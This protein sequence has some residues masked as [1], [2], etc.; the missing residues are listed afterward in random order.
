M[1]SL[2]LLEPYGCLY[3]IIFVEATESIN[4]LF[5]MPLFK[6]FILVLTVYISLIIWGIKN[7]R[8]FFL[9]IYVYNNKKILYI[10]SFLPTVQVSNQFWN[11]NV[12]K[13]YSLSDYNGIWSAR[14]ELLPVN[15]IKKW[16]KWKCYDP[17]NWCI[18]SILSLFSKLI[19][20]HCFESYLKMST[21][22]ASWWI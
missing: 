19:W 17:K 13:Q 16:N 20:V 18:S 3:D 2:I 22:F 7:V 14:N 1:K 8:Q 15:L 6:M 10:F 11:R 4:V 21:C 9:S 5:R 12:F